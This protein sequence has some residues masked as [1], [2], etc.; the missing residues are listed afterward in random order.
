MICAIFFRLAADPGNRNKDLARFQ[1][2]FSTGLVF[3]L[4]LGLPCV[5]NVFSLQCAYT[6]S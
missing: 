6:M 4:S 1:H 2:G 3:A 5:Y